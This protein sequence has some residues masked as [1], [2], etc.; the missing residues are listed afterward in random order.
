MAKSYFASNQ[1]LVAYLTANP[2]INQLRI[3]SSPGVT[4]VPPLPSSLQFL[5]ID[6]CVALTEFAAVPAGLVELRIYGCP[7]LTSLPSMPPSVKTIRVY[8]CAGLHEI[9]IQLAQLVQ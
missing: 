5:L 1:A 9:E 8:N 3:E 6:N 4:F 7:G 2:E